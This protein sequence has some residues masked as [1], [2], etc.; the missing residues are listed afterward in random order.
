[1][2]RV[3]RPRV[4][5]VLVD[6]LDDHQVEQALHLIERTKN[7]ERNL[8]LLLLMVY[9][10]LRRGEVIGLRIDDVD[11]EEGSVVVLG[12]GRKM[13]RVP[14]NVATVH[15]LADWLSKRPPVGGELVFVNRDGTPFE[16]DAV[17]SLFTRLRRQLGL[18]RLYPHL[19]RHTFAAI[20]LKRVR[21]FKSLQ[22]ILGHARAS[23]TL[24]IYA[25]FED[26]QTLKA[27]H[28]EAMGDRGKSWA[29]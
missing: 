9:S 18:P 28:T 2:Q 29:K 10:G 8:A 27:M 4:P 14:I 16:K 3:R 12:K 22:K 25:D 23:T 21:D 24:D 19:L 7:P 26:F 1:M 6:R 15:A 5:K 13:R 20:Y 11:L 17:Q